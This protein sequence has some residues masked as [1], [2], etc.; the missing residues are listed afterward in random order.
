[1]ANVEI[2]GLCERPDQSGKPLRV[3]LYGGLEAWLCTDC[4]KAVVTAAFE[5]GRLAVHTEISEYGVAAW[6]CRPGADHRGDLVSGPDKAA[7]CGA[8]RRLPDS[9]PVRSSTS[10]CTLTV[11]DAE[12][13][14]GQRLGVIGEWRIQ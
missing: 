3:L 6:I 11:N 7:P 5:S 10:P 12:Q 4:L 1:M 13:A 8:A 14:G 9:Y 2:C